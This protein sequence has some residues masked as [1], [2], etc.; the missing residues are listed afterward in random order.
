MSRGSSIR[1]NHHR[2]DDLDS[3]KV[4]KSRGRNIDLIAVGRH[5]VNHE[6]LKVFKSKTDIVKG[7]TKAIDDI[8]VLFRDMK[9]GLDAILMTLPNSDEARAI[10]VLGILTS[11]MFL[12]VYCTH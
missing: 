5:N 3:P 12:T 1:K 7:Q 11:G 6:L 8:R 4:R 9:D 2:I 10:F